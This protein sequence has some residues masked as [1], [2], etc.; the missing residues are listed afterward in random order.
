MR[1]GSAMKTRPGNPQRRE[2]IWHVSQA[3]HLSS[4]ISQRMRYAPRASSVAYSDVAY[5]CALHCMTFTGAYNY[6]SESL[7]T[8]QR[9]ARHCIK[10]PAPLCCKASVPRRSRRNRTT[11]STPEQIATPCFVA[12]RHALYVSCMPHT[13]RAPAGH[14]LVSLPRVAKRWMCVS[15]AGRAAPPLRTVVAGHRSH[16]KNTM[17]YRARVE[18]GSEV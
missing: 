18:D 11:T 3:N 12:Q 6:A 16:T 9:H 7:C 2:P 17:T 15:G 1:N 10:R 8:P 13:T 14:G 5:L 4:H